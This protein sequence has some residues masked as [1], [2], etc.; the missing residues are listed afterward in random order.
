MDSVGCKGEPESF[1]EMLKSNM[2]LHKLIYKPNAESMAVSFGA[3]FG[4]LQGRERANLETDLARL[5][6]SLQLI[7]H[8]STMDSSASSRQYLLWLCPAIA[9]LEKHASSASA[10][11]L[12]GFFRALEQ[13]ALSAFIVRSLDA[14]VETR[15]SFL[16]TLKEIKDQE[17]PED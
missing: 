8:Y 16:D 9:F 3:A 14:I 15:C 7:T 13:R 17:L 12:K 2:R 11:Q 5:F 10:T 1:V 6:G 4:T